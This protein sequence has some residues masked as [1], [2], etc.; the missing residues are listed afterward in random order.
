VINEL[1]IAFEY[2][3]QHPTML[4]L[5]DRLLEYAHNHFEVE[6]EIFT[7]CTYPDRIDH[8]DERATFIVKVN[9]IRR[10]CEMLDTPMSSKVREFLLHWFISHIKSKV[11]EYK[12]FI[13]KL[14]RR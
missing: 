13:D 11:M 14:T 4:P 1:T 9:Y 3:Q 6:S 7:K 10:Q 2:S 5:V 12:R 8:E